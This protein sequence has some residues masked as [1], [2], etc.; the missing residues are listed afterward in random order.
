MTVSP[1]IAPDGPLTEQALPVD[2]APEQLNPSYTVPAENPYAPEAE[3]VP[4]EEVKPVPGE[5]DTSESAVQ[6]FVPDEAMPITKVVLSKKSWFDKVLEWFGL[7]RKSATVATMAGEAA[8]MATMSQT[9]AAAQLVRRARNGDQNAMALIAC[10][11]DAAE[12]GNTKAIISARFMHE[13]IKTHPVG[14]TSEFGIEHVIPRRTPLPSDP[15]TAAA[16]ALSHGPILSRAWLERFVHAAHFGAEEVHAFKHG[17]MGRRMRNPNE[18]IQK[19]NHAGRLIRH[20]R[21][22]QAVRMPNTAVSRFD[23]NIGWELGEDI[24]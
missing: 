18:K 1:V 22:L 10:V 17:V 20:A 3:W 23:A 24:E 12:K 13:Y 6:D 15:A 21:K 11:R 14:D 7:A 9:E 2:I 19:A 5:I 8:S 16:V 4:M